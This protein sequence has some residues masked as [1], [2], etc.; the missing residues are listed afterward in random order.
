VNGK[1]SRGR[2]GRNKPSNP[3][4]QTY[5]SSGPE[6]KVRGSANQVFEKYLALARDAQSAGDRISAENYFQHAEHYYRILSVNAQNAQNAQNERNERNRQQVNGASQGAS[7]GAAHN[8]RV[9]GRDEAPG[10]DPGNLPQ[11][12]TAPAAEPENGVAA[13]PR[14]RPPRARKSAPR[15]KGQT[16]DDKTPESAET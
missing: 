11:P 7:Q 8:G 15:G 6:G 1:R 9:N 14:G 10:E 2:S 12:E 16:D 4:N 3:R 5:D 13:K